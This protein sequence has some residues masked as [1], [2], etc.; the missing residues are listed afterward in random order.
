MKTECG[1]S[2]WLAPGEW[3]V[4]LGRRG[5]RAAGEGL[6]PVDTAAVGQ[7]DLRVRA[8]G[9]PLPRA[10]LWFDNGAFAL[11][12]G[13]PPLP[14]E[15]D[16]E[17]RATVRVPAGKRTVRVTAPGFLP[18]EVSVDVPRGKSETSAIT[19]LAARAVD[20][21]AVSDTGVPVPFC[22]LDPVPKVLDG[23]RRSC[24]QFSDAAGRARVFVD[25]PSAWFV[26]G[27]RTVAGNT[28]RIAFDDAANV[29][30]GVVRVIKHRAVTVR[31]RG[32]EWPT[33]GALRWE[34]GGPFVVQRAFQFPIA[35][36]AWV[37]CRLCRREVDVTVIGGDRGVPFRI[38]REDLPAMPA[39]PLFDLVALDRTVRTR[40]ELQL[41]EEFSRLRRLP[42][43]PPWQVDPSS[44]DA[45]DYAR[46]RDG[47]WLLLARDDAPS[48]PWRRRSAWSRTASRCRPRT[49]PSRRA[50]PC[51]CSGADPSVAR[52]GSA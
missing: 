2:P 15:T 29:V 21:L 7:L 28:E 10:Q 39:E 1:F 26:Y 52:G 47:R 43:R 25:A 13:E 33:Q 36:A 37:V 23:E 27:D 24:A 17:G 11:P 30:D 44:E 45:I 6:A 32:D 20:V 49:A 51:R 3:D 50:S 19:L 9:E 4:K 34:G 8:A 46:R 5:G 35:D 18:A 31:L 22:R 48:T 16:G 38:R 41:P 42:V 40:A 14:S 12:A